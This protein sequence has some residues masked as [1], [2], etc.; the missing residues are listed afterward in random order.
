MKNCFPKCGNTLILRKNAIFFV[1]ESAV[2]L[3]DE[4]ATFMVFL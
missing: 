2:L 4:N 3:M 1:E